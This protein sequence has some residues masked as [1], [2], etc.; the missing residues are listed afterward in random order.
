MGSI[1]YRFSILHNGQVIGW[2]A[3]E[4]GDPP[5][6]VA[7]GQFI[8]SDAFDGFLSEVDGV[9]LGSTGALH[10]SGFAL[11]EAAFGPVP[12]E[13]ID[14]TRFVSDSGIE[15]EVT[16]LGVPYPHYATLFPHH[17]KDYETQFR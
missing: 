6:G 11:V 2:S 4:Y 17:V 13:G 14:L 12:C 7:F 3:L 5:M 16:A 10:W 8:A 15:L 9:A 1:S